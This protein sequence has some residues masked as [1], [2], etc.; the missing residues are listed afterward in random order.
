MER[1]RWG[2]IGCGNVTEVKSGPALQ[3][4]ENS[5][6]VAVMRRDARLAEDY[7]RRHS[8]PRW[9][10]DAGRLI[11]D[12]EVDAVYVATPPES[13]AEYTIRAAQAGKPVYV[14]K[15]MARNYGECE[16][17]IEACEAAGVPLFVAYYRR[18]LP[19][20][21]KVEKLLA[22]G[23]IGDVRLVSISLFQPAGEQGIEGLPWRVLPEISGGGYFFDLGSHQL[24]LLD[25]LLGPIA[26]A[27]GR[28][29]N[30]AGLYPAE[31]A[32]CAHWA[33]A[34]GILGSGVWCFTAAECQQRETIEILGSRGSI[35]CSAFAL[36]EPV[37]LET[38]AGVQEF[39]FSPPE[40][41]QQPLLQ[42]VVDEL[43]DRGACPSTGRTAA[44]TSRVMDRIVE[45]YGA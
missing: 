39:H 36:D 24:D 23:A 14:E 13:H 19:A 20:F 18:R 26:A 38:D 9:Y 2:I 45:N 8:V 32:V 34:S 29:A 10:A 27:Q 41:V 17:M 6:L 5:E 33:F 22:G 15:P 1:V 31:D 4:I 40:H 30:Q 44:R 37:R 11:A 35:R 42:T 3:K 28:A 16:R 21:L 43:L 25:Y 12:P 7:A